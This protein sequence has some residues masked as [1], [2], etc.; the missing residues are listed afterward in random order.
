MNIKKTAKSFRAILVS[1][2]ILSLF[3]LTA[4]GSD[5]SSGAPGTINFNA[6]DF[7]D[8][9]NYVVTADLAYEGKY[10][11][12]YKDRSD[13]YMDDST[14]RAMGQEFDANIY[15]KIVSSFGTPS[16]VDGN[17]R[18]ILLILDIRDGGAGGSYVAGYFSAINEFDSDDYVET[19]YSNECDMLYMD[20]NP[21]ASY[22]DTFKETMAHE[23]QHLIDFNQKVFVQG[24]STGFDTWIDE[25]MSSAAEK[26]Y[27]GA[28]ITDKITYFNSD[29]NHDIILGQRFIAWGRGAGYSVLGNY[30]TVYLFFQWLNIQSDNDNSIYKI[31]MNN[32]Y[33]DYRAVW[34]AK[35]ELSEFG[36]YSFAHLMRDWHIANLLC[37][38]TGIYGYKNEIAITVGSNHYFNNT[39]INTSYSSGDTRFMLPGECIYLNTTDYPLPDTANIDAAGVDTSNGDIVTDIAGGYS[40]DVLVVYNTS[41]VDSSTTSET[42]VLP[43]TVTLP[44]SAMKSMKTLSTA[45]KVYPIDKVIR[46][47]DMKNMK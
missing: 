34:A 5:D 41:S 31:I 3:A 39:A 10:C 1:S 32:S 40:G 33:D 35:S 37:D 29:P 16:D 12:V 4:C 46:L 20:S 17:D 14:A 36:G 28:Q 38:D 45:G 23:F 30:S 44:A 22:P 27:S 43:N 2:I 13:T 19:R 47:K 42:G 24:S 6:T 8:D 7:T 15:S 26:I 18:I 11:W 21:G 25:G 9:S